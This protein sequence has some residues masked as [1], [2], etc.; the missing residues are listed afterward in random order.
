M[1]HKKLTVLMLTFVLSVFV[2]HGPIAAQNRQHSVIV[3]GPVAAQ[4]QAAAQA[5]QQ[6]AQVSDA[7]ELA[8]VAASSLV[9]LMS[10]L[11][12]GASADD[13]LVGAFLAALGATGGG[14]G[15]D[16]AARALLIGALA[17]ASG[18]DAAMRALLSGGLAGGSGDDAAMRALLSG[19]LAGGSGD[20]AAMRALLSGGLAGGSGDDAAMRALLSG[21]LAGGSSDDAAMRALLSGGLAGGSGDDAAMRALLSGALGAGAGTSPAEDSV[22]QGGCSERALRSLPRLYHSNGQATIEFNDMMVITQRTG[23]ISARQWST[24][25]ASGDT[26]T[27]T[28]VRAR[29]SALAGLQT[30]RE[31]DFDDDI[32][33]VNPGPHTMGCRLSGQILYLGDGSWSPRRF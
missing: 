7:D 33:I 21:G 25:R 12:A 14:S 3:N 13:A 1:S 2:G 29:G 27:Y 8:N 17:A 10:A 18:D 5:G 26:I 22:L 32:P 19:G 4:D 20:D 11:A 16:A 6:R 24:Y 30:A 23:P 31:T 9:G 15:D 28:I